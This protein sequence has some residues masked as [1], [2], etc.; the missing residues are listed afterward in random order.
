MHGEDFKCP[1]SARSESTVIISKDEDFIDRWLLSADPAHLIWIRR[2]NGS[3]QA[4]LAWLE[5]LWPDAVKR[6]EQ[7]DKLIELRA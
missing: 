1:L 4:L 6:L 7:G 3:N 2:G 5:P